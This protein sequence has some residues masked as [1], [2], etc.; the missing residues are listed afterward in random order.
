VSTSTADRWIPRPRANPRARLRLFCIAHAGGGASAFRGWAEALPP[1]VEVCPVQLPGRE[2]RIAERPFD[3][4]EP[5]VAALADAVRP[6]LDLPWALFGHSNGAL[7]GFELA[8]ALR[9]RGLSGPRHLFASGRRAPDVPVQGRALSPL[10]D[11]EFLSELADL[12]GISRELLEHHEIMQM[13]L[14]VLRADVA[15]YET[16]EFRDEAPLNCPITAYGGVADAR[17]T[18]ESI[19]A[20]GRH[21]RGPFV[22]RMFPGGHFFHQSEREDFLRVLSADLHAV[23]H[24]P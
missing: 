15:L 1:E 18:H 2:N 19:E 23:L 17:T 22:V 12:G 13:L 4:V 24:A 3:R 9:A 6:W 20:W 11:D 10:P 5:L 14:P 8:R 7:I 21:T 16:Y